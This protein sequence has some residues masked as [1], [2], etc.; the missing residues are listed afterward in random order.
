VM[1][2]EQRVQLAGG[3]YRT[4]PSSGELHYDNDPPHHHWHYIG[5][6]R[7]SLRRAGDLTVLVRDRKSGFCLADH[8]GIAPGMRHG[9][10]RFLGDCD[11]YE[12]RARYVEEGSS[13]GYTDRYP[14]FFHGQDLDIT[15]VPS[16][17]YWLVHQANADFHL[18]E[19]RYDNDTA[20]LLVRIHWHAG[21]P[22]VTPLRACRKAS[23]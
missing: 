3:G 5:F 11:Q 14:A 22:T 4:L 23:C 9:P 21:A 15:K 12:P 16:G 10:P 2:V 19:A 1:E 20:S 6:D 13:V 8:W 7:Y 18:R 17:T